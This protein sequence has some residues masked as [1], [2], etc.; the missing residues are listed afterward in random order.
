M[1]K[2]ESTAKRDPAQ[3]AKVLSILMLAAQNATMFALFTKTQED[4]LACQR[5]NRALFDPARWEVIR[6][7]IFKD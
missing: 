6:E 3:E 1:A 7:I 5:I 4:D 2:I